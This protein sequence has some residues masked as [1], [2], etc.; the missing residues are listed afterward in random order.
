MLFWVPSLFLDS[1]WFAY[2][3]HNPD[4][5]W[6]GCVLVTPLGICVE[7]HPLLLKYQLRRKKSRQINPKMSAEI[8][9]LFRL[10]QNPVTGT[11]STDLVSHSTHI[12]LYGLICPICKMKSTLTLLRPNGSDETKQQAPS[13]SWHAAVAARWSNVTKSWLMTE[14]YHMT[15]VCQVGRWRRTLHYDGLVSTDF[16]NK[17]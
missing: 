17:F 7:V 9:A 4:E 10:C 8:K 11:L 3:L 15:T 12:L 6:D 1:H 2:P 16:A 13:N 5:P 14:A